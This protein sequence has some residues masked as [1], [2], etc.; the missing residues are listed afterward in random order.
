MSVQADRRV[1][2][3]AHAEQT[4]AGVCF[5]ERAHV[6]AVDLCFAMFRL[7]YLGLIPDPCGFSA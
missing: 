5:S 1:L 3:A 4:F 6:S 2:A 7:L